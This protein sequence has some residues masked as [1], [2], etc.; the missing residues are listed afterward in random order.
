MQFVITLARTNVERHTGGPF[1]AAVFE[2]G[3]GRLIGIG[4]NLVEASNYSMAHAE[5]IAIAT[6]QRAIGHYDLGRGSRACELVTSVEPC[7][8]CLGA[9]VW[10]GIRRLICGARGEDACRIGFDEGPK[11]DDWVGQ[12]Q[13]R[14]IEVIRDV[15]GDQA[16][17][18]LDLYAKGGGHI[19]NPERS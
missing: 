16:R 6:A 9:I 19:Y 11:P 18:V 3:T 10:S 12:L 15:L 7:V 4:I 5:M 17:A 8:M 14:R 13:D 2:S 1:G